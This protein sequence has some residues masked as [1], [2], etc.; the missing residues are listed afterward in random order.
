M[1]KICIIYLFSICFNTIVHEYLFLTSLE[2]A[3]VAITKGKCDQQIKENHS[4][5]SLN[6]MEG[7][8]YMYKG[9]TGQVV[10]ETCQKSKRPI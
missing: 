2:E 3:S 5:I 4:Q 1:T 8:S 7:H 6:V 10:N 9:V